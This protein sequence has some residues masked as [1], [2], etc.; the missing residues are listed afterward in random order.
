LRQ[1]VADGRLSGLSCVVTGGAGGIGAGIVERFVAEGAHVVIADLDP[2]SARRLSERLG[3]RTAAVE[4]DVTDGAAVERA[5][6]LAVSRFGGLDVMCNNAGIAGFTPLMEISDE[7]YRQ[8]F[9]V[10]VLGMI[11]GS[12]A[13]AA[14]MIERGAGRII[15]T[16]SIVSKIASP[17]TVLYAATKFAL[18][19]LT[20]GFAKEL[21]PHG[22]TVNAICPGHV[23]TPMWD[24]A[25]REF[26]AR[27]LAPEGT[28]VVET[29]VP[30][31]PLG[32]LGEPRDIAGLA[33]FLASADAAYIT[34]QSI[35]VD[36]GI[37][38]I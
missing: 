25:D 18:R 14:R 10:N 4:C 21:A 20:E 35:N 26:A 8:M 17:Q 22:I 15:T 34:A 32:R 2:A 29:L 28:R 23:D 38:S 6:E 24:D 1:V 11:H 9:D 36:G 3:P 30:Q 33:A 19:G 12:Q 16:S 31:I 27:G 13:A 7:R 37:T 5:V